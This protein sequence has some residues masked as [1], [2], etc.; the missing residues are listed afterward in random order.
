MDFRNTDMMINDH[1]SFEDWKLVRS[2]SYS[3]TMGDKIPVK[4]CKYDFAW[5]HGLLEIHVLGLE[6][7]S[8]KQGIIIIKNHL[9]VHVRVLENDRGYNPC[10]GIEIQIFGFLKIC[11]E[12]SSF[13]RGWNFTFLNKQNIF[14][15]IIYLFKM[16]IL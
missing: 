13:E 4:R 5:L 1:T 6:K 11:V 12:N 3:N 8:L 16:P 7:F 2:E 14:S 9:Q 10:L 15:S